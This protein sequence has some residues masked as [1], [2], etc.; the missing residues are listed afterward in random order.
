M[1]GRNTCFVWSGC[2]SKS[3]RPEENEA[4]IPES[5]SGLDHF[6]FILLTAPAHDYGAEHQQECDG[7]K[8]CGNRMCEENRH[9]TLTDRQRPAELLFRK[10]P[11]DQT[12]DTGR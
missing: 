5:F 7:Q 3:C 6:V 9:V 8:R 1:T 11:Q 4:L 12:D 10:R 2:G